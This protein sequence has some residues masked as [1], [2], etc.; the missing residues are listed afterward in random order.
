MFNDSL[1]LSRRGE[2]GG[3]WAVWTFMVARVLFLI[4]LISCGATPTPP[5]RQ[6][7]SPLLGPYAATPAASRGPGGRIVFADR[8]FPD[9]LNP[10]FSGSPVDFEVGAA[11][12]SAPVVF[13]NHFHVQPD[14]LTEVPLPENGDVQDNG[15]T[16]VMRLRHD[17]RWSDG[18][19]ILARDFQYW[20]QLDQDPNTGAITTGGY[21]AIASIDTPDDF[22]VILHMKHPYGPYLLYLPYA[23]PMH[24]WGHLHPID[25]Q[26]MTR[27]YL[28]PDVTDGP[29]KVTSFVN[30]QSY[31]LTPN[32]YYTS[33]TF[34]GPYISQ[35]V[36]Q[37]YTGNTAL[38]A[39][40]QAGQVDIAEGYM[41]YE[42]P[43]LTH[44]SA[45]LQ[46]LE[47]P[48]AS[49]EHL[50]FNNAN[51]LFSDV[52]VR[53]AVQL[54]IDKCALTRSVLHMA[55]CARV[56]NQVEVPPSLYNDRAI[57]PVGY[58]PA[59]A[60]KLLRQAGWLP[61]PRGILTKQG[62]P[63]VLR[64]VTTADNPLRA[65]AA[66][67]IQQDLLA[68]GIQVHVLYYPLGP[69]FAVYTRG[70]ILATGA[71]DLAMF[72]YQN[73]P[74]PDDEYGVF[75]SSQI[76]TAAEP[77]LGNYGRVRDPI[78]DSALTQGRD[79]VD[80]AQRVHYYHQFL[81]QLANQVYLIPLYTEV[82]I[83]VVHDSVRNFLPN[84]NV[85]TNNWNLSDW[86]LGK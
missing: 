80:F 44:L 70:G 8:Q 58:D 85:I 26:N 51:P 47:T 67:L 49:Y 73:S 43:A 1:P 54:A 10:L 35:L 76:P 24:A 79:T 75:H 84:P 65:A 7:S 74:E 48:A 5:V 81:E 17:L 27:V 77:N 41:E 21:D 13:D 20:W 6:V 66:A 46:L 34:H 78:I 31:T 30:G 16:I 71:F 83:V 45:S 22:T 86:W 18:Q 40:L 42:A 55:G 9:A 19:P 61:G 59:A 72:G 38:Q 11:L 32:T 50:D 82:N 29:Y 36:Y 68:V 28:A 3:R 14:Q 63:F 52:N 23:A 57:A 62:H 33:T 12:W 25:L 64:L 4:M 53:R 37:T 39:A 15:K 56:A 60:S 2:G 69:F